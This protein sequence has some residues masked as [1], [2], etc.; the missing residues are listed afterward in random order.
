MSLMKSTAAEPGSAQWY[1]DNA[2]ALGTDY[3][4]KLQTTFADVTALLHEIED[5]LSIHSCMDRDH[6]LD[7]ATLCK[8]KRLLKMLDAGS[9]APT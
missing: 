5:R 9:F 3:S 6:E 8:I 2:S 7:I 4:G 1:L